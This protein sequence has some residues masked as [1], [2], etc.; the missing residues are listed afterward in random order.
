MFIKKNS[1]FSLASKIVEIS[2]SCF[3]TIVKKVLNQQY[4]FEYLKS[5]FYIVI[6]TKNFQWWRICLPTN[7]GDTRILEF[8]PG[9]G[10][11][12]GE[13]NSNSLQY[14][15]LE[16]MNRGAW[17]A[18]LHGIAKSWTWLSIHRHEG[19]KEKS[20]IELKLHLNLTNIICTN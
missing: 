13:G 17:W 10:R 15:C 3:V 4:K 9:S 12:P 2:K 5:F 20:W 19:L 8:I 14:F 7:A 18:T 11:F 1:D 6:R 16:Y